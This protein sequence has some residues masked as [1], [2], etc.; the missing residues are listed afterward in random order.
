MVMDFMGMPLTVYLLITK[1]HEIILQRR[2]MQIEE[3]SK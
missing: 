3:N 2:S 1:I